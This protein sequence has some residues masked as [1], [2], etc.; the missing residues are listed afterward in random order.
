M[1]I[2]SQIIPLP[3]K[4]V[5]TDLIIPADFLK[6][7][8]KTGLGQ[9]LFHRLRQQDAD[10]PFNLP[11][12]AKAKIL[13]AQENFGC[14]SSR[15]HAPWALTDWG[16]KAIIA[17]S[18]GDIFYSNSLKNGLLPIVLTSEVVETIFE[19]QSASQMFEIE[20][21]VPNQ[22]VIL[23]GGESYDF[24]IDAYRKECL[25]NDMDDLDYLMAN[26]Q[27]IKGFKKESDKNLYFNIAKL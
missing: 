13:V 17:P 21:D 3:R 8:G 19:R 10:F 16:I 2:K 25:I 18:F 4:D 22:R 14:G 15:E 7:T 6:G 26:L 12:Y 11:Q 23:P 27:N 9:Y 1:H 5:D 20:I 24:E